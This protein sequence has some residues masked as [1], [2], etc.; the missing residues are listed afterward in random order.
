MQRPVRRARGRVYNRYGD[1]FIHGDMP[2]DSESSSNDGDQEMQ[3]AEPQVEA[4]PQAE[5]EPRVE[6]ELQIP[7]AGQPREPMPEQNVQD[8]APLDPLNVPEE[9][10]HSSFGENDHVNFKNNRMYGG[11]G[12]YGNKLGIVNLFARFGSN[13]KFPSDFKPESTKSLKQISNILRLGAKRFMLTRNTIN[14]LCIQAGFKKG[15]TPN[16][17]TK[18]LASMDRFAWKVYQTMAEYKESNPEKDVLDD[19]DFIDIPAYDSDDEDGENLAELSKKVQERNIDYSM[20]DDEG[21]KK[22]KARYLEMIQTEYPYLMKALFEKYKSVSLTMKNFAPYFRVSNSEVYSTAA[23]LKKLIESN[24]FKYLGRWQNLLDK[25]I[26]KG[27]EETLEA[28]KDILY[29]LDHRSENF[30]WFHLR[31]PYEFE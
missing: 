26:V 18:I 10:Q 25:D 11:N 3:E 20:D 5:E 28:V 8:P 2:E 30:T 4:E 6:E 9:Q 13:G 12:R 23:D 21:G 19:P 17:I 31:E 15:A 14:N 24:K 22:S 16:V 27:H 29:V 1:D 7:E